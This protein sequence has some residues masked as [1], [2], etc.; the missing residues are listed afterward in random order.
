MEVRSIGARPSGKVVRGGSWNNHRDNARCAYRN[1][2]QPDNRNNNL[3]FRVVLRS[4]HVLLTLLLV[5][6]QG[7]TARPDTRAGRVRKCWPICESRFARRGEGRRTAPDASGP[8]V[9]RKVGRHR[10]IARAGQIQKPG[11]G[12][13]I[14]P[15]AARPVFSSPLGVAAAA[16]LRRPG[17][18]GKLGLLDP[19]T[20]QP[21]HIRDH[22]AHMLVLTA[23]KPVP[24]SRQAK[25]EPQ[26]VQRCIGGMKMLQAPG[27]TSRIRL[28]NRLLKIQC[29]T[30]Q[31]L[32][33]DESLVLGKTLALGQK[34]GQ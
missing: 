33:Y 18:R 3:G 10:G 26:L 4:A 23:A 16:D 14:A 24:L 13:A 34:P 11:H 27:A 31:A 17:T 5:L 12:Q 1:R 20:Q 6:P 25:V 30:L 22:F 21:A 8:R 9:D 2:N 7:G 28:E 32:G 15:A 19:T 29:C